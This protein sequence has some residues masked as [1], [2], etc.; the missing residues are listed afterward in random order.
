MFITFNKTTF[1]PSSTILES[2]SHL[3]PVYIELASYLP[4]TNV[5][6]TINQPLTNH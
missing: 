6:P 1:F 4:P 5:L 2:D 3:P